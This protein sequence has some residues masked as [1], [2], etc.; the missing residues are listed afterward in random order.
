MGRTRGEEARAIRRPL[1]ESLDNYVA[2]AVEMWKCRFPIAIASTR[3]GDAGVKCDPLVNNINTFEYIYLNLWISSCQENVLNKTSRVTLWL[4][5]CWLLLNFV[6]GKNGWNWR[7]VQWRQMISFSSSVYQVPVWKQLWKSH[8]ELDVGVEWAVISSLKRCHHF[9]G[10]SKLLEYVSLWFVSLA[11]ASS[12][13][14]TV[15][16]FKCPDHTR[17]YFYWPHLSQV[18]KRTVILGPWVSLRLFISLL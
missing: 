17:E 13:L 4:D 16:L 11:S 9:R 18:P 3:L 1:L 10:S 15:S 5:V 2:A 12:F 8:S 6:L 7:H 14:W